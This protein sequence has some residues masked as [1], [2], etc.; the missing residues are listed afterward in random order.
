MSLEPL[1]RDEAIRELIEVRRIMCLPTTDFWRMG[2]V[3][4]AGRH[5]LLRVP[6]SLTTSVEALIYEAERRA[7]WLLTSGP[8]KLDP[9]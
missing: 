1:T 7:L 8:W 3:I 2:R 4:E 6:D 5:L 9:R